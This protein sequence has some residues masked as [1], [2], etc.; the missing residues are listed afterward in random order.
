MALPTLTTRGFIHPTFAD[1]T[2]LHAMHAYKLVVPLD[3]PLCTELADGRVHVDEAPVLVGPHLEQAM[4]CAGR[5][6]ALFWTPELAGNL[7]GLGAGERP[8]RLGGADA[9]WLRD[10]LLAWREDLSEA[11][12]VDT[13]LLEVATKLAGPVR[14]RRYDRRVHRAQELI[15]RS[16]RHQLDLDA[17]AA[18]VRLSGS[19][20]SHLF[21]AQVGATPRRYALWLRTQAGFSALFAGASISEAAYDAGFSDHAHFTRSLQRFVGQPPSY[22]TRLAEVAETFKPGQAIVG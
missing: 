20:L 8:L 6:I 21:R 16:P 14:P 2:G 18:A 7:D 4:G 3:A 11:D 1:A 12:A 17:I 5:A 9:R 10:A 15:A 19:R 22:V 13:L